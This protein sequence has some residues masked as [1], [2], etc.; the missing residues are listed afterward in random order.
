MGMDL[1]WEIGVPLCK[2]LEPPSFSISEDKHWHW[3]T[4]GLLI[5]MRVYTLAVLS[6]VFTELPSPHVFVTRDYAI[7]K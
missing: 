3:P 7:A 5:I 1:N 4:V 6:I 2:A